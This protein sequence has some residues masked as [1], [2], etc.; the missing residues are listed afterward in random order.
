M[1]KFKVPR[2]LKVIASIALT[3]FL[4]TAASFSAHAQKG[5][6]TLVVGDAA[7][8]IRF[9]KWLKG[10][11]LKAFEKD[12]MYVLEFWATWCGPCIAAMPGLSEFARKHPEVTVIAYNVW[13]K[14]GARPY[15][16]ALPNVEKFVKS[17]GDKMDFNVAADNNEQFVSENWLKNAGVTGIP[18]TMVVK[19]NKLIWMGSPGGLEALLESIRKGRFDMAPKAS[20]EQRAKVAANIKNQDAMLEPY[21]KAIALKDYKAAIAALDKLLA[22][23]PTLSY[24]INMKKFTTLLDFGEEQKAVEVAR[25]FLKTT[26]TGGNT[27]SNFGIAIADR[28]GLKPETYLFGVECL[29]TYISR[30]TSEPIPL[31]YDYIAQCY[32]LAGDYNSAAKNQQTA[33]VNAREGL[34]AGKWAG[35]ITKELV[36]QYEE[37]LK[38]YQVKASKK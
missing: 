7:P 4:L 31:V 37:T 25:N 18:A 36:S 8:P 6:A 27:V 12:Q 38:E 17:M 11:P 13:E 9:S 5:T 23:D 19:D 16:S 1:I 30:S 34:A 26:T 3:Y 24:G 29:Q 32:F 20:E 10:K 35:R 14:V 28:S 2:P 22:D 21:N 15:E 33:F